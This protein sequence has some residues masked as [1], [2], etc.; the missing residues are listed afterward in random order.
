ME[1]IYSYFAEIV[2]KDNFFTDQAHIAEYSICVDYT[3][4][5]VPHLPAAVI[6][7]R[8]KSQF[9]KIF[10]ICA[11]NKIPVAIRGMG[12]SNSSAVNMLRQAPC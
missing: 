11:G 9:A 12:N 1:K 6:R 5:S 8:H 10:E 3:G 2:G 7:P 4:K